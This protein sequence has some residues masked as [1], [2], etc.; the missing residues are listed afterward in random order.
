MIVRHRHGPPFQGSPG[1]RP[2]TFPDMTDVL[3][4]TIGQRLELEQHAELLRKEPA[5]VE[6][7]PT[8]VEAAE[9]TFGEWAEQTD[10]GRR[11]S[12]SRSR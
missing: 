11:A 7:R 5:E 10:C 3:T 8:R 9:I 1:S 12:W 2:R 6:G 4:W